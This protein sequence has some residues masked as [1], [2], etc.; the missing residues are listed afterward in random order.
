[1]CH[2]KDTPEVERI[3]ADPD[4]L[5]LAS[6]RSALEIGESYT[7]TFDRG[8]FLDTKLFPVR[9]NGKTTATVSSDNAFTGSEGNALRFD[10]ETPYGGVYLAGMKFVKNAKYRVEMDYNVI[11]ASNQ[12]FFQFR[13]L[14]G[15]VASDVYLA[16]P[17]ANVGVNK[18]DGYVILKDYSDY[19]IMIF[20]G[21]EGNGAIAIDNIKLTR[22]E[23]PQKQGT[24][25]FDTLNP[26]LSWNVIGG[27]TV[28]K[29][30]TTISQ[31]TEKSLSVKAFA[32]NDGVMFTLDNEV[33]KGVEYSVSFAIKTTNACKLTV[34]LGGCSKVV[35]LDEGFDDKISIEL[36]ASEKGSQLSFVTDGQ[37]ELLFDNIAVS[38][39]VPVLDDGEQP[40]NTQ[41]FSNKGGMTYSP[42]NDAELTLTKAGLPAGGEGVGLRIKCKGG[43]AGVMFAPK[44]LITGASYIVSF[45]FAVSE[46]PNNSTFYVQL[47]GGGDF[48]EFFFDSPVSSYDE[49]T[50]FVSFRL[51]A[52]VSNCLQIFCNSTDGLVMVIDDVKIERADLQAENTENFDGVQSMAYRKN[53]QATLTLTDNAELLPSGASGK[54]LYVVAESQYGG[55]VLDTTALDA[56]KTYFVSYNIKVIKQSG[57]IL[58]TKLGNGAAKKFDPSY[59]WNDTAVY[60]AASQQVNYYLVPGG[61]G[62]YIFS[63]AAGME[64]S[65]DN[66]SVT[67]TSF[68]AQDGLKENFDGI[69][70]IGVSSNGSSSI[71]T[72]NEDLPDTMSGNALLVEGKANYDGVVLRLPVVVQA[73]STY[74]IKFNFDVKGDYNGAFYVQQLG[75]AAAFQFDRNSIT[76]G[77]IC[78]N[79]TFDSDNFTLIQ[80]FAGGVASFMI[81]NVELTEYVKKDYISF[82]ETPFTSVESEQTKIYAWQNNGG[83]TV[84]VSESSITVN[85]DTE[86]YAGAWIRLPENF[87]AS[88][89]YRIVFRTTATHGLYV[90]IDGGSDVAVSAV[91]GRVSLVLKGIDGKRCFRVFANNTANVNYVISD[92][93]VQNIGEN[94]AVE[95]FVNWT[96]ADLTGDL[97]RAVPN[98][99][100][101]DSV[102]TLTLTGG[103]LN[104]KGGE[105]ADY[106]GVF[107]KLDTVLE[108]DKS[109]VVTINFEGDYSPYVKAG[110][111]LQTTP[112]NGVIT[113]TLT[114]GGNNEIRI[115]TPCYANVDFTISC[116]TIRL[117]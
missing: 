29:S 113:V 82:A 23:I 37:T 4:Y 91:N 10:S 2:G 105:V 47:G 53:E 73:G 87:S 21:S 100:S 67:E 5:K 13:S 38:E 78:G 80:I 117:A 20:C 39:I 104:V 12:F 43:F 111:E 97:K 55:V 95:N 108:Q 27:S 72:V 40:L 93:Y 94:I 106:Y 52:N 42:N 9:T 28:S 41:N 98:P 35:S 79:I 71:T 54:G 112:Q 62:L 1:M 45:K 46:N 65:I 85:S 63:S 32:E 88:N 22:E 16:L 83:S 3:P 116:V 36:T 60:S 89:N 34:T 51:I 19:E 101:G 115:M 84:S 86:T 107:L 11:S 50:G 58:Y 44:N 70:N 99:Y 57:G 74:T 64:F 56:S 109:Y 18:L 8:S 90:G 49:E 76:D 81:D 61:N 75:K 77:V 17:T 24:E 96:D 14:S 26:N 31:G 15:G 66:V 110:N 102:P 30:E 59:T 69:S 33:L 7:E 114:G 48:K 6:R 103:K 25:N 68:T 92:L